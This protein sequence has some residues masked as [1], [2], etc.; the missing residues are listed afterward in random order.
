MLAVLE[1]MNTGS[2]W[3]TVRWKVVSGSRQPIQFGS[4]PLPETGF[5]GTRTSPK[6]GHVA[7]TRQEIG[8][9]EKC[10]EPESKERTEA[11]GQIHQEHVVEISESLQS[12][13]D[14][15]DLRLGQQN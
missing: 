14:N 9:P 4:K 12:T 15:N 1:N 3:L 2:G 7:L 5:K 8:T 13:S 11:E 10:G 6:K